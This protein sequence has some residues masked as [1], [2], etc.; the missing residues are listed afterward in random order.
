MTL[1]SDALLLR[2]LS[3]LFALSLIDSVASAHGV[4]RSSDP[5]AGSSVGR[6]PR[7]L[8]ITLTEAAGPGTT[9]RVNDGCDRNVAEQ[10]RREGEVLDVG[11]GEAEPGRWKVRFRVV[12]A[13]DGHATRGGFA[14]RVRGKAECSHDEK[15]DDNGDTQIGGGEDTQITPDPGD[16]GGFPV[17]PFAIGSVVIVG[18]AL[19]LRRLSG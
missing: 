12:S 16:E 7:N 15:S 1:H 6:V 4:M 18:L 8:M 11:I 2:I 17:V 10:V 3:L 9:L 19:L 5:A 13:V 14:F